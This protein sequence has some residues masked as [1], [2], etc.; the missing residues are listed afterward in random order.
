MTEFAEML[1]E[2]TGKPTLSYTSIKYA[3]KDMKLFELYVKGKLE[4]SSDALTF[5]SMYDT[6][7]FESEK[8]DDRFFVLDDSAICMSI[9]GKA[10]RMTKKY[11]EWKADFMKNIDTE[12]LTVVSED[13]HEKAIKMINR[14]VDT[15]VLE[16]HLSGEYQAES[17]GF[18]DDVPVRGFLDCLNENYIS[19]SKTVGRGLSG[20]KYDVFKFGYDIQAYVYSA[21]NDNKPFYWVAQDKASPFMVGV[22]EASDETLASGERKFRQAVDNITS[23]LQSNED[24]NTHYIFDII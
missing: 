24:T 20:F 16:S 18:I 11:K 3:L 10:P 13:D 4:F 23:F 17:V 2:K 7:L 12:K 21:L 22:Y 15:G 1:M 9:G 14:L 19:D 8:F 6:M 5:G